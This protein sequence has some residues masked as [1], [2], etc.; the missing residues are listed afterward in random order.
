MTKWQW[1]TRSVLCALFVNLKNLFFI[2]SVL[3]PFRW[4]GG[5]WTKL[6][7]NICRKIKTIN[8]LYCDIIFVKS[9]NESFVIHWLTSTSRNFQPKICFIV[10][11]ELNNVYC[12]AQPGSRLVTGSLMLS[13]NAWISSCGITSHSFCKAVLNTLREIMG[14]VRMR[15][16]LPK[17]SQ[18]CSIEFKFGL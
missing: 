18:T 14:G 10:Y 16:H 1:N 5:F 17:L 11:S 15:I 2:A 8:S 6:K 4:W 13:I 12:L 3:S 9:N 7:G